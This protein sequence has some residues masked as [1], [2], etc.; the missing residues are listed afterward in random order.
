METISYK[1]ILNTGNYNSKQLERSIVV[2][3]GDNVEDKTLELI[4][5]VERIINIECVD[6]K[7]KNLEFQVALL[8]DRNRD[9]EHKIEELLKHQS[10]TVPDVDDPS[11]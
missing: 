5:F 6:H 4:N 9:L 2:K 8:K 3:D 11:F 1:R 10:E 7:L